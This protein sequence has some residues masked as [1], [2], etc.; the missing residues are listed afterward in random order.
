[1][2]GIGKEELSKLQQNFLDH[3]SFQCGF[4]APGM[5]MSSVELL[6]KNK[7][8]TKEEIKEALAGN[9]CRCTGYKPIIDAVLETSKEE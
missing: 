2:E 6:S 3:N 9:L 7:N 5:I 4:C 1:V 8:P